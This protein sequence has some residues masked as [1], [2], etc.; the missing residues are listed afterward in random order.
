M[1]E[2]RDPAPG[3]GSSRQPAVGVGRL[4]PVQQAYSAYT[5]HYLACVICRDVD[6]GWCDVAEQLWKVYQAADEVAYR[7]LTG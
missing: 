4:S 5:V 2:P 1:D 3:D 6:R 7:K